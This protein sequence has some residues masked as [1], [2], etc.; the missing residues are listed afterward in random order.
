VAGQGQQPALGAGV[1]VGYQGNFLPREGRTALLQRARDVP[2]QRHSR[3]CDSRFRRAAV[4]QML[5][6]VQGSAPTE[7][8]NSH[9]LF[10]MPLNRDSGMRALE[11]RG[12]V[13]IW[14]SHR[15]SP[16]LAACFCP[17]RRSKTRRPWTKSWRHW[18]AMGMQSA[19]SRSL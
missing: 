17:F 4:A 1:W 14:A 3:G 5:L 6:Q 15:S 19:T 8:G 7:M 11:K 13:T 12:R 2:S 16:A 9:E 10:G 18:T